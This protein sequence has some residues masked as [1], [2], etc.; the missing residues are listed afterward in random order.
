MH[1]SRGIIHIRFVSV[2]ALLE[3]MT[4]KNLPV[5][6]GSLCLWGPTTQQLTACLYEEKVS[7]CQLVICLHALKTLPASEAVCLNEDQTP[8]IS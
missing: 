5:R 1:Y 3:C 8:L 2:S 4:A 6:V 7:V